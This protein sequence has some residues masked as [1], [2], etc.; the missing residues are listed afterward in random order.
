MLAMLAPGGVLKSIGGG[1]IS[2]VGNM[3]GSIGAGIDQSIGGVS[4]AGSCPI[5]R[6]LSTPCRYSGIREARTVG[7]GAY[8]L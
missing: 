7:D 6:A 4:T 3:E 1:T 5:V 8:I 2:G